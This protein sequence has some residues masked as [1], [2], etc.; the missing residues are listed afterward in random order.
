MA[1]LLSSLFDHVSHWGIVQ[2]CY[3]KLYILTQQEKIRKSLD[4]QRQLFHGLE[5]L[6]I[7]LFDIIS[8][9]SVNSNGCRWRRGIK[10]LLHNFGES[11]LTEGSISFS[12]ITHSAYTRPIHAACVKD[13]LNEAMD[14]KQFTIQ[15]R[16][17]GA[18]LPV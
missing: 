4:V 16:I 18:L 6:S 9:T 17:I 10:N 15:I 13:A 11:Q 7:Q 2:S 14:L 1:A 12:Y 5:K 8:F 3:L